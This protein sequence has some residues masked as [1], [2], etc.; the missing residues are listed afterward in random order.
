MTLIHNEPEV[1][2]TADSVLLRACAWCNSIHL[3]DR[4]VLETEAIRQLRTF[5]NSAPP[6]FTHGVCPAC[7]AQLE[8]RRS[9]REDA[10]TGGRNE[11]VTAHPTP[12]RAA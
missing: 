4:W 12:L 7:F 10:R 9:Q 11:P 2:R 1:G 6:R 5:E 3:E 8:E